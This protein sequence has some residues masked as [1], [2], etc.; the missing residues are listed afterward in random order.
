MPWPACAASAAA[1]QRAA[2]DGGK[3]EQHADDLGVARRFDLDAHARQMAAGDVARSHV[4]A[5]RSPRWAS[6]TASSRPGVDEDAL[7]ARHEG[8]DAL[9][10]DDIDLDRLGLMPAALKIGRV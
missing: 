3:P 10:V 6:R 5:R 7:P 2:G 1:R 4:P 8:V 9:V